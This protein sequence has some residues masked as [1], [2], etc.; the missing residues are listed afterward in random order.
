MHTTDE[1]LLRYVTDDLALEQA[2][3]LEAHVHECAHCQRRLR[4]H[5]ELEVFCSQ[6]GEQLQPARTQAPPVKEPSGR[7]LRWGIA[8]LAS[9]LLYWLPSSG[10]L[11]AP[12]IATKSRPRPPEASAPAHELQ[13]PAGNLPEHVFL[14]AD[15]TFA[16]FTRPSPQPAAMRLSPTPLMPSVGNIN[17]GILSS[18]NIPCSRPRGRQC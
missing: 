13:R 11:P 16:A 6:L 5:A 7:G 15:E 2:Q 9:V 17:A 4:E 14:L 1:D 12:S 10:R 18:C 3:A 8:S